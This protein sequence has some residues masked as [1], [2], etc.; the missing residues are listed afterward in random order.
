MLLARDARG[1]RDAEA[2]LHRRGDARAEALVRMA[3][4]DVGIV[5]KV[6]LA[7]AGEFGGIERTVLAKSEM[8][9]ELL[10]TDVAVLNADDPRV[11]PMAELTRARVVTF[12]LGETLPREKR[13]AGGVAHVLRAY[14]ALMGDRAFLA[15]TLANACISASIHC[16]PAQRPLPSP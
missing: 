2:V 16:T 5:L 8:V 12:G 13:H 7:H 4:P 11:A 6:G 14:V 10:P 1:G 3:R 15:F 9:T